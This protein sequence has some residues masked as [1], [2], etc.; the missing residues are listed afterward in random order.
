MTDP[1]LIKQQFSADLQKLIQGYVNKT[2]IRITNINI[3]EEN[4]LE[5]GA[6]MEH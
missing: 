1:L 6:K 3:D 2:G 5:C 4:Y